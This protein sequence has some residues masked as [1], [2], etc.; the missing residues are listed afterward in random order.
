MYFSMACWA[1]KQTA[2]KL[3]F[4]RTRISRKAVSK[5]PSAFLSHSLTS[6]FIEDFPF[7]ED[8]PKH[9]IP[10]LQPPFYIFWFEDQDIHREWLVDDGA[11]DVK[12]LFDVFFSTIHH[13]QII[14]IAVLG[15][16]AVGIGAKQDDLFRAPTLADLL[17]DS[18][19]AAPIN[20]MNRHS[21]SIAMRSAKNF[22][23]LASSFRLTVYAMGPCLLRRAL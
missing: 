10:A 1:W 9:Q 13:D 17:G 7:F 21:T 19:D 14:H 2:S 11:T 22:W 8:L 23:A 16:L 15:R 5:S 12:S 4:F 18:M 20:Q 6:G 3:G